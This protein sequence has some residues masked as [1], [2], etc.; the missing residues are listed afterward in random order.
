MPLK[1][2]EKRFLLLFQRCVTMD[3]QEEWKRV[4]LR[5]REAFYRPGTDHPL[6]LEIYDQIT[7]SLN[8]SD[9]FY[10][11]FFIHAH[12]PAPLKHSPYCCN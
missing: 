10:S 12:S 5:Q 6:Q 3:V 11:P 7:L 1:G 9:L 4:C 8:L 2:L